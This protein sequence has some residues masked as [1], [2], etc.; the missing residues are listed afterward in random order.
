MLVPMEDKYLQDVLDIYNYYV[1]NSIATYAVDKISSDEIRQMVYF[2]DERF[3]AFVILE[4]EEVVGY[5]ILGQFN[6]KKGYSR[7]GEI[8]IYLKVGYTGRGIGKI[9][10]GFLEE[11][12]CERD[13]HVLLAHVTVTND[14]S[15]QLFEKLGY[16][17]VGPLKEVGYKF[18]Q[19]LSDYYYQKILTC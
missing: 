8:T 3:G 17:K 10:V 11:K 4:G 16:E 1:E 13:F 14:P 6:K 9:A 19:V 12:A 15:V 2:A 18:G 7:T 5:C